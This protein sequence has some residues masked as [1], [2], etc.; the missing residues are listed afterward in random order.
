M[1][2]SVIRRY[3]NS[4][5]RDETISRFAWPIQLRKLDGY[6]LSMTKMSHVSLMTVP[7]RE[8]W[9]WNHSFRSWYFFK[10]ARQHDRIDAP[11]NEPVWLLPVIVCVCLS[12]CLMRLSWILRLDG[13]RVRLVRCG[14]SRRCCYL[15]HRHLLMLCSSFPTRVSLTEN[16]WPISLPRIDIAILSSRLPRS[17]NNRSDRTCDRSFLYTS[18]Q[19]H[20]HVLAKR[21]K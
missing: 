13:C 12:V 7:E 10:K 16:W 3:C 6:L 17:W 20:Y 18:W 4:C 8:F 11:V 21:S 19:C 1:R 14:R 2:L 5:N 15:R 9:L